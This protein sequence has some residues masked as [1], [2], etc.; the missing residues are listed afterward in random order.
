MRRLRLVF[1]LAMEKPSL[2]LTTNFSISPGSKCVVSLRLRDSCCTAERFAVSLARNDNVASILERKLRASPSCRGDRRWPGS[3]A[4]KTGAFSKLFERIQVLE[5]SLIKTAGNN[6]AAST[7]AVSQPVFDNLVPGTSD[8]NAF[9]SGPTGILS[10]GVMNVADVAVFDAARL[11]DR[12]RPFESRSWGARLIGQFEVRM[13]R[14]EMER[15]RIAQVFRDPI[16]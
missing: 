6:L 14:R 12:A 4:N 11:R 13:K 10:L 8:Q 5:L 1:S 3:D 9:T 2:L 16:T 15:H 7:A